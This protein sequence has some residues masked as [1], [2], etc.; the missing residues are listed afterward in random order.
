MEANGRTNGTS[1]AASSPVPVQLPPEPPLVNVVVR[2]DEQHLP[3]LHDEDLLEEHLKKGNEAWMRSP[4]RPS[5]LSAGAWRRFSYL[6]SSHDLAAVTTNH[7]TP[8]TNTA[9]ATTQP[10]VSSQI[11]QHWQPSD[12]THHLPGPTAVVGSSAVRCGAV[13]CGVPALTESGEPQQRHQNHGS[14]TFLS[15]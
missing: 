12:N 2:R 14:Y 7:S 8:P 5:A 13:R 10:R 15:L 11:A 3:D 9:F 4:F 6:W 1:R